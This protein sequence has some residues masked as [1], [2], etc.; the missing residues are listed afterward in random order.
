MEKTIRKTGIEIIGDTSWGAHFC[1]FYDTKQD[2]IDILVPYF[3]TGL[4]NNEFCMWIA[5][6]PLEAKE[7]KA[8]LEKV[9]ENLDDYVE[10]GQIEI[11][12]Y[13][14]WYG[15]SGKFEADKVLEGWIEKEREA[16]KKGFDGLRL[17]GD[18]FWLEMKE[19]KKFSGYEAAIDNII[20]GH[21]MIAIC[22]YSLEKCKA[23][24]IIDVVGNHKSALIRQEGRWKLVESSERKMAKEMLG[25]SEEKF[26]AIFEGA[27]DGILIVNPETKKFLAGNKAICQ[28]LGYSLKE[29]KSLGVMDIHPEKELPYIKEQFE[30][31]VR[32]ELILAKDLPVKRKDGSI[33]YVDI[34]SSSITLAK[35]PY[36][37]GI[38]R[39][40]TERKKTESE[41]KKA[42]KKTEKLL[43]D[44][45]ISHKEWKAVQDELIKRERI[46]TTG[47]LAAGVAHEIRNPL[48]VIGMTVQYLQSKLN[49][50]DPKREL[51][52]AI[53]NKVERLDRVTK[54][55]SS[56]GRT[57]S[58]SIGKYNLKRSLDLNLALVKPKCRTQR[59]KIRKSYAKLP[60]IKMDVEQMDKAF[61]NIMD[62]A[63]QAMHKGGILTISTELDEEAKMAMVKIHNTGSSIKKKDIS[64]I[65]EL[66]YSTERKDKGTG[67]GLA[68][69]QNVII[70]HGGQIKVESKLSGKDKGVA[71]IIYLP[72]SPPPMESGLDYRRCI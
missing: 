43:A 5:S 56:Y 65:F 22:S 10:K 51:T 57:I 44:L 28:M 33:F 13:E 66:F 61:F 58:L 9:I 4:E 50:N 24:E 37:M 17:T 48:A 36:L 47:A 59:I 69:T 11:L 21:R 35:E 23:S 52:E 71:F 54:E 14:K 39:D 19:W 53:I 15:K 12:D 46:A 18:T 45:E 3:K 42:K 72:M 62:N 63:V 20:G 40:I 41:L 34:N 16:F 27:T 6:K 38:F 49:E 8:A 55:L 7:A 30:R 64:H 68:I 26:K 1:M 67:L 29:I 60:Q 2:L 25:E 31:Q 32:E 70:R